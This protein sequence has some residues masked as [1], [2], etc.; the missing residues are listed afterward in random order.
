MKGL[1]KGPVPL[2]NQVVFAPLQLCGCHLCCSQGQGS[3]ELD[4]ETTTHAP[5]KI[6]TVFHNLF[7]PTLHIMSQ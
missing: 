7:L 2:Y 5:G 4:Y 1:F 3:I 6:K